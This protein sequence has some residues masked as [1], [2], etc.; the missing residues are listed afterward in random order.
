M[1]GRDALFVNLQYGGTDLEIEEARA[2][3]GARIFTDP[4]IDRFDDLEG[5]A[6]LVDG[7]DLIITTSNV[8]A[9]FAGALGKPCWL[10]L[11]RA[12]RW[13]WGVNG[14]R[15]LFYPSIQAYR[16]DEPDDWDGVSAA[17]S[18]DLDTFQAD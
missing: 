4:E 3:T 5:F 16:Q 12:P 6:A 8:T 14:T 1:T 18:A 13:Y 11:Q 2:Q 10:A 17:L 9:H 15:S 7:L